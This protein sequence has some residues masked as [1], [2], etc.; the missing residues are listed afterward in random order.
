M[1]PTLETL[2][3]DSGYKLKFIATRMGTTTQN[4]WIIR[5]N[6][7]KMSIEQLEALADA[8]G[9]NSE[10]VFTAI[11]NF[12]EKCNNLLNCDEPEKDLQVL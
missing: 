12:D 4:L 3:T 8:I 6:P 7:R 2:I 10:T 11:K 1:K 5:R 9:V